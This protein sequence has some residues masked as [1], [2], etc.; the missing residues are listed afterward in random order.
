MTV[1]DRDER[2]GPSSLK[3]PMKCTARTKWAAAAKKKKKK[4]KKSA[5]SRIT[6]KL[7]G[8]TVK[9]ALCSTLSVYFPSG[10]LLVAAAGN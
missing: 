4:E 6:V 8:W 3:R 10:P 5:L 2:S 7:D 1:E 9:D